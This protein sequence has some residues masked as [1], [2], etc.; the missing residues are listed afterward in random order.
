MLIELTTLAMGVI[1]GTG[2]FELADTRKSGG[3][4]FL[5]VRN[6]LRRNTE[7]DTAGFLFF[8]GSLDK[9]EFD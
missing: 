4:G 2:K 7:S 8:V 3:N 1:L 9:V 6:F 5:E